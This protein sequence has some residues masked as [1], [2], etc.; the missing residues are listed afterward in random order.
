MLLSFYHLYFDFH[1]QIGTGTY[2]YNTGIFFII[3]VPVGIPINFMY[4]ND[5]GCRDFVQ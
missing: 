1:Q 3:L 5:I 2:V 4:T